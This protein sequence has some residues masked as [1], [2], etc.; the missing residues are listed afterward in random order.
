LG[1]SHEPEDGRGVDQG[2]AESKMQARAGEPEPGEMNEGG[3]EQR[4]EQPVAARRLDS[5]GA[6]ALG[7][8]A[9]DGAES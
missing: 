3:S 7:F 8:G 9:Q 1:P 6:E 2:Q 4:Q 5:E